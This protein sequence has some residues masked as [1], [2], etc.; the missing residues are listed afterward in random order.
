MPRLIT[1]EID[2]SLFIGLEAAATTWT[3]DKVMK[4][5]PIM[6][7]AITVGIVFAAYDAFLRSSSFNVKSSPNKTG[8]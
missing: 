6:T 3:V 2:N 1:G 8:A 5:S 7:K 4:G